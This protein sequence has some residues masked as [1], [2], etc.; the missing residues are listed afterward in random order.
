MKTTAARLGRRPRSTR[1]HRAWTRPPSRGPQT[2]T[3][4][5]P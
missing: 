3:A 2:A 1:K 5:R 4:P